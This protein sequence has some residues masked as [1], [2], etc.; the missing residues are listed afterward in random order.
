MSSLDTER[1]LKRVIIEH[2]MA[3]TEK[4]L[5]I[6]DVSKVA[7]VSRQTFNRYYSYLK[8]YVVGDKP[9]EELIGEDSCELKS[10]LTRSQELVR[11]LNQKV[12]HLQGEYA[13]YKKQLKSSYL[14]TLMNG[15]IAIHEANEIRA[16]LEKQSIHNALL[17]DQIKSL[18]RELSVEKARSLKA[19]KPCEI[20]K[21]VISIVPNLDLVFANYKKTQDI[22]VFEDEKDAAIERLV[23][24]VNK[25]SSATNP[26]IVLFVDR[27]LCSFS[28]FVEKTLYS[29]GDPTIVVQV[30]LFTRSELNIFK[31]K[32]PQNVKVSVI[33]PFCDSESL[34]KSQRTFNFW[35]VPDVEFEAA[36]KAMPPRIQD[37]FDE[38]VLF[39]ICQGD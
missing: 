22:D 3:G 39:R 12:E 6:Q 31:G 34:I 14:T 23:K 36:D 30:P 26:H 11:A 25:F 18:E 4:R 24:R 27:Y 2:H 7:G 10:A 32:L 35:E 5:T 19:S 38:V 8:P 37:G 28:G 29:Y 15:D 9:V 13:N 1:K 21:E 16:A 20:D 17:V 33:F